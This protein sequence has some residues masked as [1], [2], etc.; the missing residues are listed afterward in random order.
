MKFLIVMIAIMSA[1]SSAN[2]ATMLDQLR[3]VLICEGHGTR[4]ML[5]QDGITW[6][7]DQRRGDSPLIQVGDI[8]VDGACR[9]ARTGEIWNER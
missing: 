7:V 1:G 3:D 8:N 2:A 9:Y 6:S 5:N 4:V